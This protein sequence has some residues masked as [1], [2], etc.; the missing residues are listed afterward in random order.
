MPDDTTRQT[1]LTPSKTASMKAIA[2]LAIVLALLMPVDV[3]AQSRTFYGA[4]GRVTGRSI[5]GSNGS[6]TIYDA[7]GRVTGR[8]S[9]SGNQ[10][11]IYDASGRNVGR[12]TTTKPQGR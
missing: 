1:D 4:D 5:T 9:T 10:T 3:L 11:T 8:T 7:S 2:S 6:T 12:V